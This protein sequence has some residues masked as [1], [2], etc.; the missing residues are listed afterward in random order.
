MLFNSFLF[1]AFFTVVVVV[2]YLI[3]HRFRWLLLVIASLVFYSIFK[4]SF[5]LLL[6][7]VALVGYLVGLAM[8]TVQGSGRRRVLLAVGVVDQ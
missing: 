6:L 4:V 8:G 3:P 5:V 7:G 1:L 2:Y